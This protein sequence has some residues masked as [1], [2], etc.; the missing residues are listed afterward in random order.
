MRYDD[1]S[2]DTMRCDD[3]AIPS[4]TMRYDT[5]MCW[6]VWLAIRCDGFMLPRSV[7]AIRCD[8]LLQPAQDDDDDGEMVAMTYIWR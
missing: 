3:D 4:Q 8:G 2:A 1:I 6:F 7:D 5:I